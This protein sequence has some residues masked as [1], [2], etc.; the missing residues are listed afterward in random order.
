MMTREQQ[1]QRGEAGLQ[2][3]QSRRLCPTRLQG[4]APR[5]GKWATDRGFKAAS[6]HC[7][8]VVEAQGRGLKPGAWDGKSS[9][10]EC[11]STAEKPTGE[12][13]CC[14]TPLYFL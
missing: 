12:H 7:L 2:K 8:P 4:F 13:P 10:P 14:I 9:V 6:T 3:L 5:Q 1:G 11:D